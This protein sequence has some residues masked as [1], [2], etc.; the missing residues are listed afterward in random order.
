MSIKKVVK[1]APKL[2]SM[3]LIII[4]SCLLTKIFYIEIKAIIAQRLLI[5]SWEK[6]KKT[7]SEI[8]P[9]LWADIHPIGS[10]TVPRLT[11]HQIILN[12]HSGE[13][14]AFGPG[15]ITRGS[16]ISLAGHRDSHFKFLESIQLGDKI[17]LEDINTRE[18]SYEVKKIYIQDTQKDANLKLK[19]N[20]LSLVTCYPFD[21]AFS[22]GPLRY[23]VE[24]I[25][26]HNDT[27]AT[28]EY[29]QN[30]EKEMPLT[31]AYRF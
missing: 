12:G 17:V 14:L 3:L 4:A 6:S 24:A 28:E 31:T 27:L 18:R 9:W 23:I 1:M 10:L 29:R 20:T 7:Q 19:Q 26:I 8:K 30:S 13:A 2:G 25:P 5:H 16:A 15:E 21:S 22:G 11:I